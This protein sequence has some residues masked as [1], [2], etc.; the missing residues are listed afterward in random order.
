[1]LPKSAMSANKH[2]RTQANFYSNKKGT[3]NLAN[4]AESNSENGWNANPANEDF[5]QSSPMHA[6]SGLEIPQLNNYQLRVSESLV[7]NM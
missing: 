7:N 3:E 6:S 5:K 4:V 2:S 1:M